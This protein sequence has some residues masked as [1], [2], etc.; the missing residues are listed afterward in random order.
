MD[1]NIVK[2]S[3]P[4]MINGKEYTEF[5]YDF[6]KITPEDFIEAEERKNKKVY[7]KMGTSL[8]ES[9]YTFH[10]YLGFAAIIACNREIDISDLERVRGV[11]IVK[12]NMIGRNFILKS[13][14]ESTADALENTSDSTQDSSTI[15]QEE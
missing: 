12:I 10:L 4:I 5:P 7:N 13:V 11:Y 1:T 15:Q 6:D 9:D 8:Q 14:Q 3:T 2:L